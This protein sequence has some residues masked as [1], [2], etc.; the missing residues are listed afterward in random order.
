MVS[1]ILNELYNKFGNEAYHII[2]TNC[3]NLTVCYDC[4]IDDF[5]HIEGCEIIGSIPVIDDTNDCSSDENITIPESFDEDGAEQNEPLLDWCMEWFQDYV[6]DPDPVKIK[7]KLING[8]RWNFT[9]EV[10][11][12]VPAQ[13]FSCYGSW[14]VESIRVVDKVKVS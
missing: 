12:T 1:K 9:I 6:K 10:T 8:E 4:R 11:R 14:F 13:D 2:E 3:P 7:N 5:C